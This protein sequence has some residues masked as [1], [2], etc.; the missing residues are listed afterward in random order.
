MDFSIKKF[1]NIDAGFAIGAVIGLLA[2]TGL[3]AWWYVS[4][5]DYAI[6]LIVA[7]IVIFTAGICS[8]VI[9]SGYIVK[10]LTGC[11]VLSVGALIAAWLLLGKFDFPRIG[12]A[13]MVIG[14]ITG[15]AVS[16]LWMRQ[17]RIIPVACVIIVT[18]GSAIWLRNGAVSDCINEEV[19]SPEVDMMVYE[20]GAGDD[21]HRVDGSR[22]F[23]VSSR[24]DK[25]VRDRI[26]GFDNT[27]LPLHGTLFYPDDSVCHP[28]VAVI[29]G[30]HYMLD[31]SDRGY[32]YLA[33]ELVG[34]GYAVLLVD[35]NF[36]NKSF[37]G[38]YA[39]DDYIG[40]GWLLLKNMEYLRD[41]SR[42]PESPLYGRIDFDMVALAGHSR[43]GDG[44]AA[45][46]WL[47]G[48]QE[49]PVDNAEKYDFNFGIRGVIELAPT[50]MLTLPGGQPYKYNNVDYLL[51]HGDK[52]AD[53]SFMYGLR[54]YNTATYT[55]SLYHFKAAVNIAGANH[56]QFNTVWGINDR[57]PPASWFID[58]EGMMSGDMQRQAAIDYI[59]AFLDVSLKGEGEL[60]GIFVRNP[61]VDDIVQW[62]DSRCIGL[63]G[64]EDDTIAGDVVMLTLRDRSGMSQLNHGMRIPA[65]GEYMLHLDSA[66]VVSRGNMLCFSAYSDCDARLSVAVMNGNDTV[67][68][69][70]TVVP[71]PDVK[72]LSRIPW[73]L[74]IQGDGE[75]EQMMRTVSF[76]VADTDRVAVTG[77][78]FSADCGNQAAVIIDNVGLRRHF[79]R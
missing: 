47:N 69:G 58:R 19:I 46:T 78:R 11:T 76:S 56:G 66:M 67:A 49:S 72:R 5:M 73:L 64:F 32:D 65:G 8:V 70:N 4:F 57:Q 55:D 31:R 23:K 52:D 63:A 30:S 27:R 21:A 45:A 68:V 16:W 40:R 26:W 12:W 44:I 10:R 29:H 24:I 79:E 38:G 17:Y 71:A 59:S 43:G 77:I 1:Q 28:L 7:W 33:R 62:H 25:F 9:F 13:M 15:V 18:A 37:T 35:Q 2:F 50:G 41:M 42:N 75:K 36:I 48:T 53:V 22:Y 51:L 61:R 39:L 20:Y 54:R 3:T 14:G 60:P 6:G 74:P 34:R